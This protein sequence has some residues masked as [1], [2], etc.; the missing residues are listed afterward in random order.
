MLPF[1]A[2][3]FFLSPPARTPPAPSASDGDSLTVHPHYVTLKPKPMLTSRGV[4]RYRT[5]RTPREGRRLAGQTGLEPATCGFGDRCATNC[6]TALRRPGP[7]RR[8][9]RSRART[10]GHHP[11]GVRFT[12]RA[13]V[14]RTV[15]GT[16]AG[17]RYGRR[18]DEPGAT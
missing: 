1:V 2:S 12:R 7:P 3:P 15:P 16:L 8:S 11:Q 17:H 5:T 4:T 10:D 9:V 13:P 18:N 6:A 14:G